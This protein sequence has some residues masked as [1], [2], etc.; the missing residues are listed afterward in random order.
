ML[1]Q[2]ES[3][4]PQSTLLTIGGGPVPVPETTE[5]EAADES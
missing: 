3:K 1:E 5:L 4:L 2:I